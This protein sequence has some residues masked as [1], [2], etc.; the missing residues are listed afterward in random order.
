MD[1]MTSPFKTTM[2]TATSPFKVTQA[3]S[4]KLGISP[5]LASKRL[6]FIGYESDE[7]CAPSLAGSTEG[8]DSSPKLSSQQSKSTS[9]ASYQ[10]Y[11]KTEKLNIKSTLSKIKS[12]PRLYIGLPKK[13]FF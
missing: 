3:S 12:K 5:L 8:Y 9:D 10:E 2:C 1:S 11:K 7:P 6:D 13:L 4:S